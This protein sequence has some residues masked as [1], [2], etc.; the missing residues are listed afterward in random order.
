[1]SCIFRSLN[2]LSRRKRAFTLIELLIVIIIIGILSGLLLIAVESGQNKARA[3]KIVS[4]LRN[5]KA[6]AILSF[7]DNNAWP[8]EGDAS[9][10][11]EYLDRSLSSS[12]SYDIRV[13]NS[14]DKT[15]HY[16][17]YKNNNE[18]TEGVRQKLETMRKKAAVP[19]VNSDG[20][21]YLA[22]DNPEDGHPYMRLN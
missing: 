9:S 15:S 12:G 11:D 4:N 3:T 1:M 8:P 18:L 7:S 19:L 22:G 21:E 10:L 16:V 20:T 5:A 13:V 17:G 2:V 14:G 6:A